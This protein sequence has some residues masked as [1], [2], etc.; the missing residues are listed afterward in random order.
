M[1][2]HNMTEKRMSDRRLRTFLKGIGLTDSGQPMSAKQF[3]A[4]LEKLG[5][6]VASQ[7]TAAAFGVSIRQCQR[8]AIGEQPVPPPLERLL[9]M[10][11]KH[12]LPDEYL[13]EDE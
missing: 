3:L 9:K 13:P 4:I 10:Y 1:K 2:L 7:R 11:L 12:G 8:L 5:L 6:T